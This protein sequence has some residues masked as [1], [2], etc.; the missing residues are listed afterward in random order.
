MR[1]LCPP[2][3][4]N[5][6]WGEAITAFVSGATATGIYTGRVLGNVNAQ[7]PSIADSV[8]CVIYPTK[9]ADI[10]PWTFNDFPSVF[11]PAQ[12]KNIEIT[13]KFAASL[14][15]PDGYIQQ[16]HAAPG[17]VLPVLK[18]INENPAYQSNDIIQKY[19]AEVDLM[20]GAAAGGFNLG[21]ESNA[22]PSNEKAGEVVGSGLIAEMVQRVILNGDNVD[23]VLSDTAKGIEAI[24]NG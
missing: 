20:S 12:S 5:Y 2:G 13:K 16:L 3:A 6:S 15:N 19:P 1:E 21:Y 24:M 9:S 14:F 11:I 7:N 23:E 18:S 22:H 4:T 17:H 8:T 10:K